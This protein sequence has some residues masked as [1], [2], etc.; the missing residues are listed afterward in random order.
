MN[1]PR[2]WLVMHERDDVAV[3]LTPLQVGVSIKDDK[4]GFEVT[5]RSDIPFG[6]KFAI[7]SIPRGGLVNKY[8]QVIGFATKTIQVGD[9]VHIH[10]LDSRRARGDLK[11]EEPSA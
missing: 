6:H 4:F 10:N 1:E 5:L 7:H 2:R 11:K 3:A 9:H 8:G